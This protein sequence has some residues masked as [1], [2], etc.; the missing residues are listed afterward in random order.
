MAGFCYNSII[1]LVFD[2]EIDEVC[3]RRKGDRNERE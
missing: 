3:G 2:P 1:D